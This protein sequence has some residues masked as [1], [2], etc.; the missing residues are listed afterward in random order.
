MSRG[1]RPTVPAFGAASP[2]RSKERGGAAKTERTADDEPPSGIVLR[3]ETL[4]CVP[5]LAMSMT[6]LMAMPLD[7]R[8]GFIASFVDGTFTVE[9]I[10][11]ASAMRPEEALAILGELVARGVIVL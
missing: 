1:V 7:H 4:A 6:K 10:L 9:N 8:A 5:R 2:S 3:P 11:D